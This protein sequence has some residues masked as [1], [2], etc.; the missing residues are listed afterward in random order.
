M[1]RR[2]LPDPVDLDLDS[3]YRGLTL[4][5]GTESQPCWVAMCMVSSL[6][7]AVAVDGLSGGLGGEADLLALSRLRGANDVSIVGAGTVRDEGYV[8]LTGSE[9][10]R[11]DRAARGLRAVP[12]IAIV[13]ASGRL[14]PD[15]PIFGDPDEVP[16]VV[17][18]ADADDDALAAIEDRAEIHRLPSAQVAAEPLLDLLA[19]LGLRRVLCEGGPRLNQVMLAADR[20]DELFVT[21]APTVVGGPAPRIV[22]GE[23]E[24]ARSLRLVTVH[25]HGGDLLLRYRHERHGDG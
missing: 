18:G 20:L 1:L 12:R 5:T 24:T 23:Q 9:A 7:G 3:L 8:P 17:A 11:V 2:L 10:R 25:E 15:L 22:H 6:D 21:V 14:D 19:G 16:L 13:T 4:P